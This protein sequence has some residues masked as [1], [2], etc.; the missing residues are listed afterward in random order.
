MY[1][2]E[3]SKFEELCLIDKAL[4]IEDLELIKSITEAAYLKDDLSKKLNY[5][6][7]DYY[8]KL[9]FWSRILSEMAP[10]D[11]VFW[12]T[13]D[14]D[15][16]GVY[17]GKLDKVLSNVGKVFDLGVDEVTIIAQSLDTFISFDTYASKGKFFNEVQFYG[18]YDALFSK[19][20]I[21]T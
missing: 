16:H 8:E 7:T 11:D 21:K 9:P 4:V 15:D 10:K 18:R 19:A 1:I 14:Y 13:S 6:T 5:E 12:F 17:V 20:V 2:D 3:L